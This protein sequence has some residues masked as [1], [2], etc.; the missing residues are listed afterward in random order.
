MR[1]CPVLRGSQWA[2]LQRQEAI[3]QPLEWHV[4]GN[5]EG[6]APGDR[7]K[8]VMSVEVGER[9][10]LS[11]FPGSVRQDGCV[12]EGGCGVSDSSLQVAHVGRVLSFS[13]SVFLDL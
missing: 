3:L 13:A 6:A 5:G 10:Q 11:S 12:V 7:Q 8:P 9:T 1:V 4:A 2:G